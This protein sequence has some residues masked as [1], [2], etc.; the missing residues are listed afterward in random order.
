[1][2]DNGNVKERNSTKKKKREKERAESLLVQ[3]QNTG[4]FGLG[5]KKK[6]KMH[7]QN[8]YV[9]F[10]DLDKNKNKNTKTV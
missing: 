7:N 8:N 6:A 3:F 10:F 2:L 4:R 1:M 9:T 5:G